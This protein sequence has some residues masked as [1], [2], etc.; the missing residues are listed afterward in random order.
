MNLLEETRSAIASAGIK[1]DQVLWVG[2]ESAWI[3]WATFVNSSNLDYDNTA[4]SLP[5]NL[6]IC[7]DN[8][9]LS[10]TWNDDLNNYEWVFHKQPL[11]PGQSILNNEVTIIDISNTGASLRSLNPP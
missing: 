11:K 10:R 2:D 8:W 6:T 9:W 7:G 3:T 4:D 5:T 1:E